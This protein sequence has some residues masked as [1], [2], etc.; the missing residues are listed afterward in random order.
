MNNVDIL[1]RCLAIASFSMLGQQVSV[2]ASQC[3][4]FFGHPDSDFA[5]IYA[6]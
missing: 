4:H 2:L 3:H 6:E 5:D 1:R